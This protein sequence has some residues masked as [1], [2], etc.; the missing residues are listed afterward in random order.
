M[1]VSIVS[2]LAKIV[3]HLT[4]RVMNAIFLVILLKSIKHCS[5]MSKKEFAMA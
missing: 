5:Y 2:V 4:F 1:M 3:F